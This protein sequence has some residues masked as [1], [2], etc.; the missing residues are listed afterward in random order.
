LNK[1]DDVKSFALA[2]ANAAKLI[3]G[4]SVESHED[5]SIG[6]SLIVFKTSMGQ[7]FQIDVNQLDDAEDEA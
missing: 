6:S 2:L 7:R 5:F 4:V 3:P 1:K